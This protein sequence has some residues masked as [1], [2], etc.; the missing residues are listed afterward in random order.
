[1]QFGCG[2]CVLIVIGNMKG[3]AFSDTV[4]HYCTVTFRHCM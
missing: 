1:M 2:I 4:V 3:A